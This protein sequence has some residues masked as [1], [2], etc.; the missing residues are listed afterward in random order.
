MEEH[1]GPPEWA[2][3]LE[4]SGFAHALRDS[5]WLYPAANLGHIL[6]LVLLAGTIIV[7]DLRILGLGRAIDAAALSRFVTP[8]AAA[9]FVIQLISGG[10][11]FTADARAIAG[12]YVFWIK[13][14]LLALV[15]AN[16]ILFR[17]LWNPQLGQWDRT[18]SPVGRAQAAISI[19]LWLGVALAG[20]LIAYF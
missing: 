14:G 12:N 13:M 9:G 15:L 2:V 18:A 3:T 19:A 7:L 17:W 5:I 6:G 4:A 11:M 20:R 8:L 1:H 10:L 16:A